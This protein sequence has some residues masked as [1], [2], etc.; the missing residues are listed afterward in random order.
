VFAF[1]EDNMT[2]LPKVD[3]LPVINEV[4]CRLDYDGSDYGTDLRFVQADSLGTFG[5]TTQWVIESKGL[6]SE[7]GGQW[8]CQWAA[9]RIFRRMAG[10]EAGLRGGAP[11]VGIE[12]F[13]LT[14]PVWVGD[15]VTVSHPLM[16]DLLTGAIGVTDRVYE[17][18]ERSPDYKGGR[19]M[20]RLLD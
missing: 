13:F 12:A 15:Y 8:F 7:L 14:L 1:D 18:I 20:Y 4:I 16:P 3:R 19:M 5:R 10:R 9:S 6:R 2:V 17:V 11:V